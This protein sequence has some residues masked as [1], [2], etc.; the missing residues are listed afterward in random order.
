MVSL[1]GQSVAAQAPLSETKTQATQVVWQHYIQSWESP[2]LDAIVSDYSSDSVLIVNGRIYVGT[3]QIREVFKCLFQIFDQG[4]NR[5]DPAVVR[6]RIVYITWHFT[7]K[8]EFEFFGTD[9]FVI[10]NGVISV[11]T[12]ASPLYERHSEGLTK[13]S[14]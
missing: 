9:T 10:E 2:D 8:R 4:A 3:A 13:V 1:N 12:I 7:P 11:Q 14:G 6:D 5:I